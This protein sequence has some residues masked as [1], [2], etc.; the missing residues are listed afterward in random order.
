MFLHP[1]GVSLAES[2]NLVPKLWHVEIM[3][4]TVIGDVPRSVDDRFK[5]LGILVIFLYLN[6]RLCAT[7]GRLCTWINIFCRIPWPLSSNGNIIF[8]YYPK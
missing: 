2:F 1:I 8:N 6:R 4:Q 7:I 3:M 5:V